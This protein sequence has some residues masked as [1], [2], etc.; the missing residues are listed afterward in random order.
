[1][2]NDM[3]WYVSLM[4]SWLPFLT[5]VGITIWVGR[6]IRGA[7]RTQDGRSVAQAIDDHA[8]ELRRVNGLL[9]EAIEQREPSTA[10]RVLPS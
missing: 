3:P 1:M 8:R 5:L 4:L 10:P 6:T 2:D 7:L 9:K